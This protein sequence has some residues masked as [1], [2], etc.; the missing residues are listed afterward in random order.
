MNAEYLYYTYVLQTSS[1]SIRATLIIDS[2]IVIQLF[3]RRFTTNVNV[4]I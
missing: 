4:F 3:L 2:I 1:I